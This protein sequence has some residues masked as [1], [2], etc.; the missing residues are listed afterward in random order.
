MSP[1]AVGSRRSWV[2]VPV[3]VRRWVDDV[4]GSPVVAHADQVGGMSPG[5]A[6][7]VACASGRRA[8]VKAVGAELNP[9]T[10]TLF[11]RERDAL[12]LL[13]SSPLWADLVASYDEDGDA[14]HGGDAGWV[15]LVLEDVEGR[16][17]DLDDDA[18]AAALLEATDRLVAIM[19]ERVVDLPVPGPPLPGEPAL[20]APGPH[21]L[22]R[23]MAE[24]AQSVERLDELPAR[25]VPAWVRRERDALAGLLARVRLEPVD[26][27]VH[28]DIRDDNLLVRP[29]GGVVFLDWGAFGVGPAWTDPL[30]ARLERVDRPWFDDS[31][32]SS[33][34]LVRAGDDVVTGVLA[35]LG[36]HLALR[37]HTARDVGLPGL[38]D[39]RRRESARF[40]GGA[41][42][43]LG[44]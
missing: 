1:R 10:P 20:Y 22:G 26:H 35:G 2:D 32:A 39:F 8:F 27:V 23:V 24:W 3:R 31:L 29:D 28:F 11:R 19:A 30:L 13:G 37:A 15:A 16:H 18:E 33:P 14:E 38:A 6:A 43:R 17:P 44:V 40:L 5:C 4:L 42:R 41:A 9:H 36:T 25:A 7:R 34:A 21:D 12:G